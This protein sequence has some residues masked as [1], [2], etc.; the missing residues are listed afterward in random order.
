MM[1]FFFFGFQIM[2][3]VRLCGNFQRDPFNDIKL[4][5]LQLLNLIG[6]IDEQPQ[7]KNTK[8]L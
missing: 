6:I 4:I 3:I 2:L 7:I 8:F 5:L 1:K